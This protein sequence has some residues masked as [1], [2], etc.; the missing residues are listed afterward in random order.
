MRGRIGT[1]LF[2]GIMQKRTIKG[3]SQAGKFARSEIR[4]VVK[5]VYVV[6]SDSEWK[7]EKTGQ[8]RVTK[9][10]ETRQ[11]AVAYAKELSRNKRVNLVIHSKN[12]RIEMRDSYGR[13]PN[14][15]KAKRAL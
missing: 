1:H 8:E 4:S 11:Q 2:G 5:A 15:R 3:T 7:V 14:P 10:F 12:G 13:E 9:L 6:P